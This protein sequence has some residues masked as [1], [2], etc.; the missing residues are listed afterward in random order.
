MIQHFIIEGRYL[1]HG[2]RG[3]AVDRDLGAGRPL[4]LMFF[5]H[6][7]GEVYAKCP[8][9]PTTAWRAEH[10]TCRKCRPRG[11]VHVPGSIWTYDSTFTAAFPDAVLQWELQRHLD[12]MEQG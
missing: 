8:V 7:C 11:M 1:G 9:E 5:C 3:L 2:A 10:A 6:A 4:S 12:W